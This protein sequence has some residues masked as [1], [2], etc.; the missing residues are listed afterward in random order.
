MHEFSELSDPAYSIRTLLEVG[1][2]VGSTVI[3]LLTTQTSNM[4]QHATLDLNAGKLIFRKEIHHL[5]HIHAFDFSLVALRQ[6]Q[7]R[8]EPRLLKEKIVET[9]TKIQEIKKSAQ[10]KSKTVEPYCK[11]P[12]VTLEVGDITKDLPRSAYGIRSEATKYKRL[13]PYDAVCAIFVL[14]AIP[15]PHLEKAIQNISVC[16]RPGGVVF[17][18]DYDEKDMLPTR[19]KIC[20]LYRLAREHGVGR[21]CSNHANEI[22]SRIVPP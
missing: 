18:R 9:Q 17:V 10:A 11:P 12:F 21:P 16:T 2:G 14:S 3:P 6:L 20:R 15:F 7:K 5:R 1:C 4:S 22:M 13:K 19:H 8:L